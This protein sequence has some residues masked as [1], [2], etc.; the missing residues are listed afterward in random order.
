M[1]I[2]LPSEVGSF[3]ALLYIFL[4]YSLCIHAHNSIAIMSP[5]E[6]YYRFRYDFVH[7]SSYGMKRDDG[8]WTGMVGLVY[9]GVISIYFPSLFY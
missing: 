4:I 6:L 7:D 3:L 9:R 5:I 8:T 2:L 1:I